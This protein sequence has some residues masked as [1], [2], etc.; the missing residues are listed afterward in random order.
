MPTLTF[1]LNGHDFPLKPEEY[2]MDWGKVRVRVRVRVR[3]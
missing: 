3:V 2:W 1:T